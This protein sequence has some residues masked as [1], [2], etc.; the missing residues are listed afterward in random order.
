MK[1]CEDETDLQD[2]GTLFKCAHKKKLNKYTK[3]D[4]EI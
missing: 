3:Q 1:I 2:E 4:K